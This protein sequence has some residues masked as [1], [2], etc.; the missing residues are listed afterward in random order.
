MHTWTADSEAP[1]AAA[2]ALLSRPDAWSAWA[3]HVRGAWGLGSPEVRVG[4][5]GAAR[6]LGVI[7]VPAKIRAKSARSWTWRV[8]PATMVHRVV[9][10]GGG[11]TVAI[12]LRAPGR[13]ERALAATYGPVIQNM[14]DRLARNAKTASRAV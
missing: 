6:L 12:D 5:V 7:P 1:A 9:E 11:C 14:L 13:L 8:G 10:R 4:A 2:W 3:P